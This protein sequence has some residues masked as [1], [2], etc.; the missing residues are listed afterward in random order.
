MANQNTNLIAPEN[1]A[2]ALLSE[3]PSPERVA[4]LEAALEHYPQ[5]IIETTHLIHGGMCARTIRI[6][7][8]VLL[9]GAL[10]NTQNICVMHGDITVTTSEG[11]KRL[12]GFHVIPAD[13]GYKRAGIAHSDTW[14]TTIWPTQ[15]K[16]I[17]AIEDEMTT[18][19]QRLQTR[20]LALASERAELAGG[21]T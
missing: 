7:A 10:L 13:A 11:P 8:G 21:T 6:P 19:A 14:W 3:M 16:E 12:T 18:E 15:E 5:E 9:T 20:K 4:E 2:V 1:A 17:E